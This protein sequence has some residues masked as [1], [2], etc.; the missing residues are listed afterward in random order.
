VV[1]FPAHFGAATEDRGFKEID[2]VEDSSG[3]MFKT[4][5]AV[6][7]GDNAILELLLDR[8]DRVLLVEVMSH[9]LATFE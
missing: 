8:V 1:L 3:F 6:S 5:C 9:V 4:A 2:L 7:S